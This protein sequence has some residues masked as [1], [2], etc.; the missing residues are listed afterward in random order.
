VLIYEHLPIPWCGLQEPIRRPAV[1]GQFYASDADELRSQ[2]R[3]CFTHPHGPGKHPPSDVV[4]EGAVALLS[5]HAG[6]MYSGP[7]A[8]HGYYAISG[9]RS[10]VDVVIILGPNHWGI[11]SGVAT[12]RGGYWATPLGRA[13]IDTEAAKAIVAESGFIDFDE[14]AHSREHSIEVQLPFLQYIFSP[15]VAFVPICMAL[16]DRRTAEDVGRAVARVAAER[17]AFIIASSDF[18]HYEPH[19]VAERKD[20]QLLKAISALNVLE[21]YTVLERLNVTACGY[22]PIAAT[23]TAAKAL[24]AV[25]GRLLKYAT[26]GDTSGRYDSVVGYA[27]MI[28][29]RG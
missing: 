14:L 5:P 7:V 1:S 11:G 6:Y 18:T 21:H 24:G 19:E 9:L 29:S 16:Q 28:F 12:F 15:D 4:L 22:G 23:L 17:R 8:A 13:R 2:I 25:S 26:S 3:E 27:S 20:R 10:Q